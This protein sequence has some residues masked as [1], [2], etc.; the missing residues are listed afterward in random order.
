LIARRKDALAEL[1]AALKKTYNTETHLMEL[2]VQNRSAVEK[3]LQA[4]AGH[5]DALAQSHRQAAE[6][7]IAEG[8]K[9]AVGI[10]RK[11]VPELAQRNAMNEI[12]A[13]VTDCLR[14]LAEEPRVVV[15]VHDQFLDGLQGRIDELA[16]LSA[17]PGSIVLIADD[18]L[19]AGD[20]R[21]EWA[22]GG[23]ERDGGRLWKEIDAAIGRSLAGASPPLASASEAIE[24][25]TAEAVPETA[26]EPQP[27]PEN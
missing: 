9:V 26:V 8:L 6:E 15:R 23:A 21:V 16:Q 1:S 5:L 7:M 18:G 14:H 11:V 27:T 12:E 19:A 3:T 17:F 22:D 4:A 24:E 25:S 2:D 10:A 20:C 13:L